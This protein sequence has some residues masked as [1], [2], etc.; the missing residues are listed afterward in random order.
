MSLEQGAKSPKVKPTRRPGS[1][2]GKGA[3]SGA[4]ANANPEFLFG[5]GEMG[6]LARD[7]QWEA[8]SL[9]P[10]HAWPQS[11]RAAT[12][13]MMTS[14][15]QMWM[16]WG[17][18]LTFLY[19]DAYRPTLGIKHAWALGASAREVWKEIWPEIG[20]RIE[21]VL[22]GGEATWDESLLLLLERSGYPEETYHTFSYSP[23]ADDDGVNVGM[24]CVV[25]EE[26]GAHY[27]RATTCHTR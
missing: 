26:T 13:I 20:P 1:R 27:R 19:N 14:R 12:R 4:D 5:T 17:K 6:R 23:L 10:L 18:D 8:T 9:G 21:Q 15:Y 11:L 22:S 25:T 7:K 2:K 24:L 16:G 3:E